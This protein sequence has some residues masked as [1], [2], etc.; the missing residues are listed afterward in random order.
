MSDAAT[1]AARNLLRDFGEIE[2][3]QVSKKG[4]ADFV[5]NADLASEKTIRT[6]LKKARPDYGFLAEESGETK[7]RDAGFR[8]IIDPLDGTSNFM[9]GIPLFCISIGLEKKVGDTSEIIAG[10]VFDALR[11]DL[12]WAEKGV[13]AFCNN[14]RLRVSGREKLE[15]A[16][17]ATEN[18][19][20]AHQGNIESYYRR[21]KSVGESSF[22]VRATGSAA[23]DLVFVAAGK[24]D[25]MWRTRV[26]PW[27]V[28]AGTIIIREA[29]GQI[30]EIG[31]GANV[32]YGGTAI[33]SNGS[34]HKAVDKCLTTP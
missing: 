20:Y 27:D 32:I 6:L 34:L 5:T 26:K 23:L 18:P 4:P 8:W 28:A 15:D 10:V 21:L 13:G 9:H 1:K 11:N 25:C 7:G 24:F 30:T 3:L 33:A 16:L 29:G 19:S 14:R 31:G 2:N 22:G 17:V 12:Y